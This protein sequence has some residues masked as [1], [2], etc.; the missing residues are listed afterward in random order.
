MHENWEEL[1]EGYGMKCEKAVGEKIDV[2]LAGEDLDRAISFWA[3][4]K[5]RK[6]PAS[7]S[8]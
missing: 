6:N 3:L 8:L 2:G 5:G 7:C 4:V 1:V